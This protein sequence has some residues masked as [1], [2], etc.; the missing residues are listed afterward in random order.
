MNFQ[1]KSKVVFTG[2][3]S[4]IDRTQQHNSY[5]DGAYITLLSADLR[6]GNSEC[7]L[8]PWS[9][10]AEP[11]FNYY[12]ITTEQRKVIVTHTLDRYLAYLME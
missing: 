6:H 5:Y 11:A 7:R 4:C 3:C 2:K 8:L 12:L 1:I 10:V 9:W